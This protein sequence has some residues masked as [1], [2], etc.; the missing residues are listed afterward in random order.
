MRYVWIIATA[1]MLYAC[2]PNEAQQ[3]EVE[4]LKAE[5]MRVREDSI[6]QAI[7]NSENDSLMAV[8]SDALRDI[9]QSSGS[10]HSMIVNE[11]GKVNKDEIL[12][13][14]SHVKSAIE[15]GKEKIKDLEA[16]LAAV[17]KKN[18]GL[19]K[20]VEQL[21]K[22][23]ED[24][25]KEIE[26]LKARIEEQQSTIVDLSGQLQESRNIIDQQR[27]ELSNTKQ[28]LEQ[29]KVSNVAS[30]I[31]GYMGE[32]DVEKKLGDRIGKLFNKK[33]KMEAYEKALNLYKKALELAEA[34]PNAGFSPATIK[35]KIAEIE[36]LMD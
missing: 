15:S 23:I 8:I 13:S 6:R 32:A 35:A 14:L 34:N 1:A 28:N 21:K 19:N 5:L 11:Q 3:K 30:Q 25:Q 10:M 20:L 12:T 27:N 17:S 4:A 29:E 16:R 7:V 9:N 22:E 36:K 2:G 24:K 26:Q 33:K 18:K 31:R